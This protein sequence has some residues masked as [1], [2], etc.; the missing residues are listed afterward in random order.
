LIGARL[1]IRLP[2]FRAGMQMTRKDDGSMA[3][4]N[5]RWPLRR[6]RLTAP[7]L[8]LRRAEAPPMAQNNDDSNR[9]RNQDQEQS[10]ETLQARSG[11]SS[12]SSSASSDSQSQDSSSNS[13]S[14]DDEDM[15][16]SDDD[17]DDD[18]RSSG[19]SNRRNSIG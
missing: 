2:Y 3:C 18:D 13:E 4:K 6:V 1:G 8:L 14:S 11:R 12:S 15:D 16:E 9:D 5:Q 7:V 10:E 17:R 19:G